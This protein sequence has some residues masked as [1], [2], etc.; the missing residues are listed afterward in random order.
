[1]ENKWYYAIEKKPVGPVDEKEFLKLIE[2][3]TIMSDT[4]V[5]Q[6]GMKEWKSSSQVSFS[7][8]PEA[9]TE[10][11]VES[12]TAVVHA[13]AKEIE[14]EYETIDGIE[15]DSEDIPETCSQCGKT[16]PRQD[17]VYYKGQ[18]VCPSCS[19]IIIEKPGNS[20]K[21][22]VEMVYAD[23]WIRAGAKIIDILILW[24]I[25]IL[26]AIFLGAFISPAQSAEDSMVFPVLANMLQLVIAVS[27]TTYFLGT[28]AATPGKMVCHLKVVTPGGEKVTYSQ[29]CLR[30]FA[31]IVSSLIFC[32]GYL[33]A[34]FDAERRTLH[35]RIAGTRVI[36]NP[37]KVA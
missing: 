6:P 17:M 31:E 3:G 11:K 35:D 33:M 9:D 5:W 16:I 30:Y 27:Y 14:T 7:K 28:Y 34:I 22:S 19:P 29:A 26:V 21:P 8:A 4:L 24:S 2:N 13:P 18:W 20:L 25:G 36:K 32:I 1:M 15:D 12:E 23:F 37:R 10:E